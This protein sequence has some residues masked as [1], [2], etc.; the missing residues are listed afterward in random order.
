M[1]LI[2]VA[3]FSL[4]YVAFVWCDY[5]ITQK[6]SEVKQYLF[7]K[8]IFYKWLKCVV[9]GFFPLSFYGKYGGVLTIFEGLNC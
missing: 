3:G 9:F 5:T 6:K 1:G 7:L 2:V 4:F 8:C